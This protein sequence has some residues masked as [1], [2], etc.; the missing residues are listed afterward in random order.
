[1]K[2]LAGDKALQAKAGETVR[3]YFV[4]GGPNLTSSFHVIGEIFDKAWAWGTLESRPVEGVQTISV[5]P[6]GATIV[7][8]K[9]DVPG[10]YKLVDHA[11]G[12]VAKGAV[13]TL[14]VTGKNDP[15]I[16]DVEG[17]LPQLVAGHDMSGHTPAAGANAVEI[18][19]AGTAEV[20]MTDNKF[21][22]KDF[23]VAPGAAVTF[24]LPNKGKVPH[25]LRIATLQGSFDGPQTVVSSPEIVSPEK[26]GTLAW[27]APTETGVYKFRCDI[28]PVE[29]FGT[30]TVQ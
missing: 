27:T 11:L 9:V 6:G 4:D 10:D 24:S 12:R 29:M 19:S 7:Q 30:I 2:A 3:I 13:G 23:K 26:V 14:K 15:D 21:A 18:P 1:M 16:F 22:P 25:N 17:G 5:P 8:F 28:H 20:V